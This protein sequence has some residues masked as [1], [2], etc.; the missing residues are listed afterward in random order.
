[1][2][3]W[4][5]FSVYDIDKRL[6][7]IRVLCHTDKGDEIVQEMDRYTVIKEVEPDRLMAGVKE[8]VGSIQVSPRR[9]EFMKNAQVMDG[10]ELFRKYYQVTIKVK[11]TTWIRKLL[12]IS[13]IYW[14]AAKYLKK[15]RGW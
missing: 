6:M 13:G 8:L 15:I 1:M 14:L 5:C 3:I 9:A 7:T 12:L 10:T 11:M 2:I 4:D